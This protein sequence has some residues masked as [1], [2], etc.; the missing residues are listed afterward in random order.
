MFSIISHLLQNVIY[1]KAMN[2]IKKIWIVFLSLL[3][4]G[5]GA[6]A[7]FVIGGLAGLGVIAGFSIY[8][9]AAP[10]DMADAMNFFSTCWSCQM[11]GDIMATMSNIL[12]PIY[13]AI[14]KVIIP[15]SG[16]LLCVWLV[17]HVSSGMLASKY[18]NGWNLASQFT[19]RILKLGIVTALLL[20][21]LPRILGDVVFEPIFNIG[22]TMN[23][24]IGDDQAFTECVVAT[25]VADPA[26][27]D[28][29]AAGRGAFSPRLR[30]NLACELAGVHQMTALGMTAGWTMLNMSFNSKY[31]HKMMWAVPIFPNVPMFFAGLLVLVL[32]FMALLPVPMYFLQVFI[33]LSMDLI[34]LP[35]MFMSWVF[36][37]WNIMPG[38]GRSIK[39]IVNDVVQGTLGIAMVGIFVTFAV[40]FLTSAFGGWDGANT[41]AAAISAGDATVLIDGLMLHNDSLITIILMGLFIAMFMTM[42]PALVQSLFNVSIPD[43]FYQTAANNANILWNNLKKWATLIKK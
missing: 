19:G 35:L 43:R 23:H 3:P 21:P 41:L 37:G 12:P 10:V 16:A 29:A 1:L 32:F 42:I 20:A 2:P 33:K 38:G 34:M 15:F 18:E 5:A 4:F 36:E 24:V 30:H 11:F 25:A 17:W 28:A 14:G 40:M 9:T 27:V 8:R 31:M 6:V 13:S 26:S 39:Q 22:L 7:P